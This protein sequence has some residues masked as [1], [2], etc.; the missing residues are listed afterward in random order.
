MS[1]PDPCTRRARPIA[2]ACA[3]IALW[4]P[5][6]ACAAE[7]APLTQGQDVIS[8]PGIGRVAVA[9]VIVAALAVGAAM[10]LRRAL[11]KLTGVP[12]TGNTV[13]ILERANL[14][15]GTRAHLVQVEGEKLLVVEN[16][17]GLAI[18]VLGKT[19]SAAPP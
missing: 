8:T 1:M 11:P 13:R 19:G 3:W 5:L 12:L 15:P 2:H 10:A 16:R 6:F 7:Q 14:G 4:W 9:F 17:T 18:A